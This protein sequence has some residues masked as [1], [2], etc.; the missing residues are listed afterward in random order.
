MKQEFYMLYFKTNTHILLVTVFVMLAT[1]AVAEDDW[2]QMAGPNRNNVSD[3]TG[4]ARTWPE[5]GPRVLWTVSL[6]VGFGSPSIKDG[7]VY[8]LD[9]PDDKMDVL[10]CFE[11]DTGKELWNFPYAAPGNVSYEGSRTAP[12]IDG[13][14]IY[15]VGVLGHFHCI[16][17]ET[18]QPVW[19]KNIREDFGEDTP[20]WGVAQA[21]SIY[22]NLVIVAPQA[23]DAYVVAYNK[24]TGELVWKSPTLGSLGYSTPVIRTLCGVDQAVMVTAGDV[25][26]SGVSVED[27][28]VLWQYK[29]W[30]CK[31]PIPYATALPDDRLFITGGYGAGSAMIQLRLIDGKF[32]VTELYKTDECGSQIQQPILFGD[33]LYVNSNSNERED[34]LMCLTLDGKVKWKTRDS[35]IKWFSTTFER[36][37]LLLADGLIFDLDGKKGTLHLIEPSPD[38][39]KELAQAPMLSGKQIWS[40]MALSQ[41]K[42]VIRSQNEMKCLDVKNP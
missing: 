19:S 32:A 35:R 34:G 13:N 1:I 27:G 9:K 26:V 31:I 22:K 5:G 33:H 14:R 12:T 37:P 3:E 8:V 20:G 4:I 16:D 36:G 15:C 25:G 17:L 28:S 29:N 38:E 7:K 30:H 18:H 41:G 10:R 21:P 11:L 6:G 24:E 42:L 40:P 39:Y 2:P 23:P